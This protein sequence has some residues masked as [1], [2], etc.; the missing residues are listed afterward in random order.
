MTARITV[1]D[2]VAEWR[3]GGVAE[4]RS[5]RVADWW[6]GGVAEWQSGR[7]SSAR[8]VSQGQGDSRF[9][10]PSASLIIHLPSHRIPHLYNTTPAQRSLVCFLFHSIEYDTRSSTIHSMPRCLRSGCI[11]FTAYASYQPIITSLRSCLYH[12]WPSGLQISKKLSTAPG[13]LRDT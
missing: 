4:W 7:G 6:R 8:R 13:H 12:H 3:S 11:L 10:F 2:G 1:V 5:G 9:S